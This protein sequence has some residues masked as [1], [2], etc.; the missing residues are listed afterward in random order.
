[1]TNPTLTP[2][3]LRPRDTVRVAFSGL[4]ARPLRT[5]LAA[6][7][8]AV[9]IAAMV[10]VVGIS[11]SSQ[12]QV[13]QQL[14]ELGTDLLRTEAGTSFRQ[15]QATLPVDS[16]DMAARIGAVTAASAIG[17]VPGANVYR[18]EHIDPN[19]TN[20]LAVYAAHPD[21]LETV[22][23]TLA[24]GR[25]VDEA[26]SLFPTVVLG[27]TAAELLGISQVDGSVNVWLG[28]HWFTVVGILDQ[29]PLAPELNMAALIGWAVAEDLLGFDRSPTTLFTRSAESD[30]AT[31]RDLLPASVNPSNPEEVA[32]GRPSDALAAQVA[33]D[34]TLT[35]LLLALGSVALL[36]GG[37]GVANTMVIAVIERRSEI[38]LRRALGASR[39]H[40][41]RQFLAE[42]VLLAA[43]GGLGGSL[44]GGTATAVFAA[45][46][47]WSFALPVWVLAVATVAT[48]LIGALSGVYPAMRAARLSPTAALSSV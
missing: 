9:G 5:V 38:G 34:Q 8:I 39:G 13:N 37:I 14:R 47:G 3:R 48:V 43:L 12:E 23:G 4:R 32:V 28:G 25:F 19:Q 7:G 22:S 10:A 35:A 6:L 16:V 30:V 20:A 18:N 15:A 45:S 44:L 11:A 36:V 1:M 31:V 27:T 2:A 46:R 29:V 42:S 40:I 21:L 24:A 33:V 17:G 41:R 26:L